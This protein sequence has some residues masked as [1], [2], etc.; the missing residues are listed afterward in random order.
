M[1]SKLPKRIANYCYA[2]LSIIVLISI[3]FSL[4]ACQNGTQKNNFNSG[5]KGTAIIGPI[6]PVSRPGETNSKPY[7]DAL[8]IIKKSLDNKEVANIKVQDDGSFVISL[9]AGSYILEATNPT[10]SFLPYAQTMQIEVIADQYIEVTV[11]FDSG[12]R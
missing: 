7:P 11:N 10:G 5:I 12:I 9:P 2:L 1:Q 4:A 3:F 6:Q 8:I